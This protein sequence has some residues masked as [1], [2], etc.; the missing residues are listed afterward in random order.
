[1]KIKQTKNFQQRI[2]T[3]RLFL[4][5][6]PRINSDKEQ[7]PPWYRSVDREYLLAPVTMQSI[8]PP[9]PCNHSLDI[10]HG[11]SLMTLLS[12]Q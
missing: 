2:F 4:Y 1:M 7:G 9:T 12:L 8:V 10:F 6:E 11:E 3:A 5:N